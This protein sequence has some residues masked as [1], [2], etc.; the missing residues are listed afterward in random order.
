M[1][2]SF[3][4]DLPG[5][6][7]ACRGRFSIGLSRDVPAGQV[8]SASKGLHSTVRFIFQPAEEW[9]EGALAMIADGLIERFP[10][11]E[12]YGLH[13]MPGLPVGHLETLAGPMM[14]AEDNFEIVRKGVGGHAARP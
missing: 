5:R 1:R 7:A 9:G 10:F 4:G 3:V 2:L 13:N 14:S 12:I 8:A 11:E 6:L